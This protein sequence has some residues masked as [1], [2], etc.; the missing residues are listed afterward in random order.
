[1]PTDVELAFSA[2]KGKRDRYDYL[3]NMY[4]G[5][6]PL[7]YSASRLSEIFRNIDANFS[8][9]WCAVVVDSVIDRINI[10][11]FTVG[12]NEDAG[13]RLV[14]LMLD[15]GL[16]LDAYDAHLCTLV[17]GEAAILIGVD[18]DGQ[19]EAYY[20]DSRMIHVQY[21]PSR[22]RVMLFAAKLWDDRDE[23]GNNIWRLTLYYPDRFE[24]HV[25]QKKE[26]PTNGRAFVLAE[27]AT[28]EYSRIPVFHFT[29]ERRNLSSELQNVINPQNQLNKILADMMVAAEFG[30]FRQRYLISQVES[31]TPLKNM[32]GLVWD[33]PAGDGVGQPTQVGE[34]SATELGNYI[35]ALDRGANVIA[36][37]SRTPK[38]YFS[39]QAACHPVNH[40]RQWSRH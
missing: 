20:N 15:T 33:I 7:V 12:D 17:T 4:D 1:M 34:L 31:K 26:M 10:E 3:W 27:I 8:E 40:S 13:E 9:N 18:D 38:H 25:A 5:Q 2:I 6:H 36:A 29:R 14:R 30:A 19:V 39:R 22:P 37:I 23:L 24:Y 16:H 28:N 11:R 32:P 35:Q 21:D